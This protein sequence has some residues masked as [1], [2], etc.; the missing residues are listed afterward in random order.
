[1]HDALL[2]TTLKNLSHKVTQVISLC[3]EKTSNDFFFLIRC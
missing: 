3:L 2:F 1:M